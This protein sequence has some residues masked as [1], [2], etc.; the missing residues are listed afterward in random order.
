MCSE[1]VNKRSIQ[2]YM[3]EKVVKTKKE[4]SDFTEIWERT[5]PEFR[6]TYIRKERTYEVFVKQL[7][8]IARSY[9]SIDK[10][11]GRQAQIVM[12]LLS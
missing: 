8:A 4:I 6:E 10:K 9:G 7:K 3:G 5:S 1:L 12:K 2:Q 11:K